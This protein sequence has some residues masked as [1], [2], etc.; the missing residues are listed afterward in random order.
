MLKTGDE[1]LESLRDGRKVYIGG[2]PVD[3]VTAHP[4][5]R[6]G[7]RSFAMLY[8]RKRAPENV[9]V[10]SF[11]EDGGALLELVPDAEDEGRPSQA[12]GDPPP[13]RVLDSRSAGAVARPCRELRHRARHAPRPVRGDPAGVRREHGRLLPAHA[14]ERRVCDL[15]RPA[16]PR[17]AQARDVRAR[18]HDGPDASRDRRGRCR[19]H[20]QRHED[21]GHLGDLRQR[22]MGRQSAAARPRPGQGVDHLRRSPRHGRH[23]DLVAEA[24]RAARRKR[25]RQPARL[26]LRRDRLDGD[27]QGREGAV[28]ARRRARQ[29]RDVARDLCPLAEPRD[30]QPPV[31]RALPRKDEADPRGSPGG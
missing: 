16:A 10:M 6:N 24:L 27:L 11:E 14:R 29:C 1:H 15:H 21:A 13:H 17:R 3:D 22:D 23:L 25:V 28:G 7:A 26:P 12:D 30:G 9:D 18:G 20:P 19:G 5:F 2:T 31:E 8:D 4:A